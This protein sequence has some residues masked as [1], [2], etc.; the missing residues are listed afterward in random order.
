[1]NIIIENKKDILF[2][3]NIEEGIYYLYL[4]GFD[5]K[6]YEIIK[7]NLISLQSKEDIFYEDIQDVKLKKYKSIIHYLEET[8]CSNSEIEGGLHLYDLSSYSSRNFRQISQLQILKVIL[9]KAHLQNKKHLFINSLG[10][11]NANLLI[12]LKEALNKQITLDSCSITLINNDINYQLY[13]SN[14]L[15]HAKKY[16]FIDYANVKSE[17]NNNIHYE[18]DAILN[19]AN[20][21]IEESTSTD[22][23][24]KELIDFNK[25]P[26]SITSDNKIIRVLYK[27]VILNQQC[28]EFDRCLI[29]NKVSINDDYIYA[30]KY[31]NR[32]FY[33]RSKDGSYQINDKVYFDFTNVCIFKEL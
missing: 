26:R 25:N 24:Y 4:N 9:L 23:Y 21:F 17:E 1:M 27:D 13:I 2:S 18:T 7:K 11:I 31:H 22:T 32:V 19:E 16:E 3:I 28:E 30:L 10:A 6:D 29:I 8:K 33:S 14:T 5:D 20:Y 12:D 15:I